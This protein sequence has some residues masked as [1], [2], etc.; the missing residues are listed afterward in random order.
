MCCTTAMTADTALRSRRLL[1]PCTCSAH[2][3]LSSMQL[4][5]LHCATL[6]FHTK[7]MHTHSKH[8]Q[9]L[10]EGDH[11][12]PRPRFLQDSVHIFL[13]NYLPIP[14]E[15][16]LEGALDSNGGMSLSRSGAPPW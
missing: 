12:S 13:Q 8:T 2:L 10:V 14:L 7:I 15:Y 3:K 16:S 4:T 11:N 6:H 9:V 5:E 1:L